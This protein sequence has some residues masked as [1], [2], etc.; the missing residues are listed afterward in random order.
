MSTDSTARREAGCAPRRPPESVRWLFWNLDFDALD[1]DR[2]GDAIA[3]MARILERGRLEDVHW[4]IETYG[5]ER[6]HRFFRDV[7]H[8][9]LGRRT[10]CFW[11]AV[12][13]AEE[14]PWAGPPDWRQNSSAPWPG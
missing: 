11:R 9:E 10:I 12:F 7:G 8:P 1:I 14:E 13:D 2:E 6:I 3:I 5:M 4:V